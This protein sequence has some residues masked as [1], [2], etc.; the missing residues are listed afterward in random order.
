MIPYEFWIWTA[1]YQAV[2]HALRRTRGNVRQ[3]ATLLGV[4][5]NVFYVWLR[6]LR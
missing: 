2:A 6:D 5:R 3:A 4:G 1:R